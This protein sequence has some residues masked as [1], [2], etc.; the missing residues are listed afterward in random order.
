M[1][2]ITVK[3][4][5]ATNYKPS[6]VKASDGTNSLTQ[7]YNDGGNDNAGINPFGRCA[8]ALCRKMGWTYGGR[9]I[10]GGLHNGDYVFVFENSDSFTI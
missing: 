3:Y 10:S 1:K 6:R 9:L 4:L 8:V 5:G 7:S 2:A